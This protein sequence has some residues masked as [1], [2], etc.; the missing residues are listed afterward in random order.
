MTAAADDRPT[1]FLSY[2]WDS[3]SHK[4]WVRELANRLTHYGIITLLDQYDLHPGKDVLAFMERSIAESHYV[5]LICTPRFK[6]KSK[7]RAGGVGWEGT[8]VTGEMFHGVASESKFVPILRAGLPA[9]A[10]PPYLAT[11]YYIDF[12]ESADA[13]SA[14]DQLVRHIYQSPKHKKPA[15]GAKPNLEIGEKIEWAEHPAPPR[16]TR[17][18]KRQRRSDRDRARVFLNCPFDKSYSRL[19]E[20]LVFTVIQSGFLPRSV[21]EAV[22]SDR[23]RLQRVFAVMAGCK[24]GIHDLS[25]THAGRAAGLGLNIP[26][27]LG[28][29]HG[30]QRFGSSGAQR[31][32]LVLAANPYDLARNLSDLAGMD[33]RS[34]RGDPAKMITQVRDWLVAASGRGDIPSPTEIR[35]Q[36]RQFRSILPTVRRG[37][38]LA[39]DQQ[40][41]FILKNALLGP[42]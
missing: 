4:E 22:G 33:V 40:I 41:P 9:D 18:P 21:L 1:C 8:I 11:K 3:E 6:E 2:S 36:Y 37:L 17:R 34:H 26:F 16:P 13:S 15:L 10:L 35:R 27:E 5:L 42:I 19:L 32:S 25:G 23:L 30:L 31:R 38:R 24:Y 29:F 12:S 20:A 39:Q 7:L 28:V 14:L